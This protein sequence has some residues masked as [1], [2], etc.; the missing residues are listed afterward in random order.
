MPEELIWAKKAKTRLWL[1]FNPELGVADRPSDLELVSLVRQA[2]EEAKSY[3]FPPPF[4]LPKLTPWGE[5][6]SSEQ[7]QKAS[8]LFTTSHASCSVTAKPWT[9][10]WLCGSSTKDPFEDTHSVNVK[11]TPSARRDDPVETDPAVHGIFDNYRTYGL[12]EAV[13][14]ALAQP[15][16]TTL[17]INLPTGTGKTLVI[18]GAALAHP[19]TTVVVVPTTALA[20]DQD[21]RLQELIPPNRR[22]GTCAYNGE[23][24]DDQKF[25]FKQRL[26]SGAMKIAF[27]SPEALVESLSPIVRGLARQGLLRAIAIDEAHI[28]EE[29]GTTFRSE[30]QLLAGLRKE[31][32]REQIVNNVE[33]LR[34]L[35]LTGTL[36]QQSLLTMHTLFAENGK[37]EVIA[38]M[39]TRPEISYWKDNSNSDTLHRRKHLLE[40]LAH[41]SKPCLVYVT[42]RTPDQNEDP[43][44]NATEL[45]K[46]LQENGFSRTTFVDGSTNTE[47]KK[48]II[49]D[50]SSHVNTIPTIDI[51]VANS[52]FGLGI[53]IEGLRTVIHM[54]V[55][56]T[57]QRFYQESGRVGR[58]GRFATHVWLPVDADWTLAERMNSKQL[59]KL[60][61]AKSRWN[62]MH[63]SGQITENKVNTVDL[64][65]STKWRRTIEYGTTDANISWN[66]RTLTLMA[67]AGMIDLEFIDPP[68]SIQYPD[69][70]DLR[71]ERE[72]YK[73]KVR[74]TINDLTDNGW[75]Q[76]E[77]VRSAQISADKA[78]IKA[79]GSLGIDS[80]FNQ[81]FANAF[82]IIDFPN[83]VLHS[84]PIIS[85]IGC[86]GCP[87]CRKD[88]V[89][90]F[91]YT[92]TRIQPSKM[93]ANDSHPART[94]LILYDPDNQDLAEYLKDNIPMLISA[95]YPNILLPK[96]SDLKDK[97]EI[98]LH[99]SWIWNL[100]KKSVR[101]DVFINFYTG[102]DLTLQRFPIRPTILLTS[103]EQSDTVNYILQS[104]LKNAP[105]LVLIASKKLLIENGRESI[106]R[107]SHYDLHQ[108]S[109]IDE[110][111]I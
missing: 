24:S 43:S 15:A 69:E 51:V 2:T 65:L 34:T 41:A 36:T 63:Q 92:P 45:C 47:D 9:P 53:D 25:D 54:C 30:F 35:L 78:S 91:G 58:D 104:G 31:V 71:K 55:P 46:F 21:Q 60:K 88:N 73:L 19:G 52:A 18:V 77:K 72:S 94:H 106:L 109:N 11:Q 108:L 12:R 101:P 68:T 5:W 13:R 16:G 62:A 103:T 66:Q 70:N 99:D 14:A 102:L 1:L 64:D 97:L 110:M 56:E 7:W 49:R 57:V 96:N 75:V 87:H 44:E 27:V 80:C 76:F 29:W 6:P 39:G 38:S 100:H 37:H 82:S 20:I 95:G 86:A 84:G 90:R 26:T 4:R 10:E 98:D 93:V 74:V 48:R 59:L 42:R 3:G 32:L 89:N 22:N 105:S 28:V 40:T 111:R 33:P 81:S 61:T 50:L 17:T 85:Q 107:K 23:M 83:G 79:L 67:R 8:L